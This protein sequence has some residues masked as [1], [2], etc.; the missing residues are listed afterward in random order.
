MMGFGWIFPLIGL[1]IV[2]IVVFVMVRA[3]SRGGG[4]HANWWVIAEPSMEH[5]GDVTLP[6]FFTKCDRVPFGAEAHTN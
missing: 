1:T 2:L 3:L 4:G 6:G 5:G